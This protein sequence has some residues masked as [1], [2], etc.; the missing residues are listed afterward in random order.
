MEDIRTTISSPYGLTVEEDD[1]LDLEPDSDKEGQA[2]LYRD[3]VPRSL[4]SLGFKWKESTFRHRVSRNT[5]VLSDSANISY[6][7]SLQSP[8]SNAAPEEQLV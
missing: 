7:T 4:R 8:V 5:C 3:G 6:I 2:V 1:S